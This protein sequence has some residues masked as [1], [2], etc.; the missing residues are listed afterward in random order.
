[1]HTISFQSIPEPA[2]P[3]AHALAA[4]IQVAPFLDREGQ[5][6]QRQSPRLRPQSHALPA[7]QIPVHTHAHALPATAVALLKHTPAHSPTRTHSAT[8]TRSL[9]DAALPS[10]LDRRQPALSVP[11]ADCAHTQTPTHMQAQQVRPLTH[12]QS[13]PP[14]RPLNIS[15]SLDDTASSVL[16][17]YNTF[18]CDLSDSRCHGDAEFVMETLHTAQPTQSRRG[19]GAE[20]KQREKEIETAEPRPHTLAP[21]LTHTLAAQTTQHPLEK[22]EEKQNP[23]KTASDTACKLQSQESHTSLAVPEAVKRKRERPRKEKETETHDQ[24]N[25]NKHKRK[26]GDSKRAEPN[27][28][29][30]KQG[31]KSG[32]TKTDEQR[33]FEVLEETQ[34]DENRTKTTNKRRRVYL[35]DAS[36]SSF[37]S[38]SHRKAAHTSQQAEASVKVDA[39]GPGAVC[40]ERKLDVYGAGVTL[41]QG[42]IQLSAASASDSSATFFSLVCSASQE[43]SM[44]QKEHKT[45]TPTQQQQQQQQPGTHAQAQTKPGKRRGRPPKR[46]K[47]AT[48]E[49]EQAE[50]EREPETHADRD[51]TEMEQQ[52]QSHSSLGY[53]DSGLTFGSYEQL[54]LQTPQYDQL[55]LLPCNRKPHTH[56]HKL[57]GSPSL[58]PPLALSRGYS[59][60]YG[61]WLSSQQQTTAEP[62]IGR[63]CSSVSTPAFCLSKAHTSDVYTQ[64]PNASNALR[65]EEMQTEARSSL[66]HAVEKD[67]QA[68]EQQQTESHLPSLPQERH[69]TQTPATARTAEL[70]L[71]AFLGFTSGSDNLNSPNYGTVGECTMAW[72]DECQMYLE[73]CNFLGQLQT[74][75]RK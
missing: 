11:V 7:Q 37:N 8:H 14:T 71:N 13:H 63:A 51:D 53:S 29:T 35:H 45:Q 43:R 3:V 74:T 40:S 34:T 32:R 67:T 20:G 4:T 36:G 68:Q 44:A 55:C 60:G 62:P 48:T 46:K 61:E 41:S 16:S 50:Q 31:S 38:V 57:T 69:L 56:A 33:D 18:A 47:T 58:P 59:E 2:T 21:F 42:S 39:A 6:Q 9:C 19:S 75:L 52:Q 15:L 28:E 70:T 1:M 27:S 66:P 17:G 65:L 5:Q 73:L 25:K 26:R 22:E 64:A 23:D 30:E 54:Q 24:Q 72:T 49:G 12:S 10:V